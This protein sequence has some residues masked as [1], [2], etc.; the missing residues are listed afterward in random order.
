M[1]AQWL[2]GMTADDAMY[3]C[4]CCDDHKRQRKRVDLSSAP[5]WKGPQL[6]FLAV[7]K[8]AATGQ[9]SRDQIRVSIATLT[10][11]SQSDLCL[12]CQCSRVLEEAKCAKGDAGPA[13][14]SRW[15][16]HP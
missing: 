16:P 6:L 12:T 15:S 4:R 11:G 8:T 5:R 2:N 3:N 13:V 14:T 10:V 7:P 9:T 1:I